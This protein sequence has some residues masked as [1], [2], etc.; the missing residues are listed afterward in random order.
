MT[1][2]LRATEMNDNNKYITIVTIDSRITLSSLARAAEHIECELVATNGGGLAIVKRDKRRRRAAKPVV[3]GPD[4]H[5][6]LDDWQQRP[7]TVVFNEP[8]ESE[9]VRL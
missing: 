4:P 2:K 9:S 3:C 6:H 8:T 5:V 1:E 7:Q